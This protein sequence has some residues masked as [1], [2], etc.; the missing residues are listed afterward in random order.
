MQKI[1][2]PKLYKQY[3]ID[4]SDERKELFKKIN[5][6]YKPQNCIYPGSFVHISPSF[7]IRK[8]TYIDADKRISSFFNNEAVLDYIKLNKIYDGPPSINAFQAD[9]TSNLPIN[10]S[11]FDIMFSF[12]AGFISQSCKKYLKD[13]GLLV[14]NNSHGDASIAYTDQD[15]ELIAVVKRYGDKFNITDKDLDDYFIKKDGTAIDIEKVLN[16]MRGENFIKKGYAY[17]FKITKIPE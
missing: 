7:Y 5:D 8:M 16:E 17:I 9:Y 14:C 1:E 3:F 2:I 4:K 6:L 12:Y 15:Y 10:E 13:M 11:A